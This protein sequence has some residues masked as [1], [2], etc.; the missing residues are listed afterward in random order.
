MSLSA[1]RR[2]LAVSVRSLLLGLTVVGL[3]VAGV[4]AQ[5]PIDAPPVVFE[6][7]LPFAE[8]VAREL[9]VL[10]E[11]RDREIDL[12]V[13][14]HREAPLHE[15]ASLERALTARKL[16]FEHDVIALQLREREVAVRIGEF[17]SPDVETTE[18]LASALDAARHRL[19]AM[20][21]PVEAPLEAPLEVRD[22]AVVRE[23]V[24]GE[25]PR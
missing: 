11:V 3:G 13:A 24:D 9:E 21:A 4:R 2:R 1:V 18:R 23:S 20:G 8:R 7:P 12:L 16:R 14:A 25:V 22:E 5:T 17:E 15:R 19:D 6:V 10:R